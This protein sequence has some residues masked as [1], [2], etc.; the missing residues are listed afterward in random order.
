MGIFFERRSSV[1]KAPIVTKFLLGQDIAYTNP[2]LKCGYDRSF[3]Y[4]VTATEK[5]AREQF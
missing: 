5:N 1:T 3:R 2:L 4:A